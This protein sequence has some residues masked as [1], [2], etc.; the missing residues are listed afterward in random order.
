MEPQSTTWELNSV[1][2]ISSSATKGEQRT[3]SQYY[4]Q[5]Q[6]EPW[7]ELD[8]S[9]IIC[10]WCLEL[11]KGGKHECSAELDRKQLK[12]LAWNKAG[13]T[14]AVEMQQSGH[15]A[16]EQAAKY[17]TIVKAQIA[18]LPPAS[19][20]KINKDNLKD[21]KHDTASALAT[22][23]YSRKPARN[24]ASPAAQSATKTNQGLTPASKADLVTSESTVHF[25]DQAPAKG[26]SPAAAVKPAAVQTE[27][28]TAKDKKSRESKTPVKGKVQA[29]AVKPAADQAE[30][31]KAK[32]KKSRKSKQP[33]VR[34][35]ADKLERRSKA[36]YDEAPVRDD[37]VYHEQLSDWELELVICDAVELEVIRGSTDPN[38]VTQKLQVKMNCPSHDKESVI[39]QLT[40]WA[41]NR[42]MSI[43]TSTGIQMNRCLFIIL[44]CNTGSTAEDMYAEI[45]KD[46][47]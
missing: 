7:I 9:K 43:A 47:M 2:R 3:T 42:G 38:P 46:C 11:L 45:L 37:R 18:Q 1:T 5:G 17:A 36:W 28:A 12:S 40:A 22:A 6:N 25:D 14:A 21:Q 41:Y 19:K 27:V 13:T 30:V 44:A 32:N 35:N 33:Q 39:H 4:D 34:S 23:K 26:K 31:A 8:F 10:P 15:S 29:D 24:A 20:S 16:M